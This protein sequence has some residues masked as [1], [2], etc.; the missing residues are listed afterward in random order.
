[1][2]SVIRYFPLTIMTVRILELAGKLTPGLESLRWS[3]V[4]RNSHLTER[5]TYFLP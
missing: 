1:M 5:K 3:L 4:S 2:P